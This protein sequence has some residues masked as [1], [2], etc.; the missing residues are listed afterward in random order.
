MKKILSIFFV[1]I[2]VSNILCSN[3]YVSAEQILP[4]VKTNVSLMGTTQ[5]D[6]ADRS[7]WIEGTV[8]IVN[9]MGYKALGTPNVSRSSAFS[10]LKNSKIWAIHAHGNKTGVRFDY[11][12][13]WIS[14]DDIANLSSNALSNEKVVIFGTCN[15]GEGGASAK[16]MVNIT[17]NKG[18]NVVIGFKSTTYTSQIN[19]WMYEFFV[20]CKDGKNVREACEHADYWTK[21]YHLGFDGGT[22][23]RLLR[24]GGGLTL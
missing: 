2:I 4:G 21:F 20:G 24:G 19:R 9:Q 13:S 11:S 8:D 15:A 5:N 22:G 10:N 14:Y 3:F 7:S 6:N 1:T 12:N 23:N 17:Y 18:A 16:N